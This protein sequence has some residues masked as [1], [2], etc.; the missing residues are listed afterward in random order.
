MYAELQPLWGGAVPRLLYT[1][2]LAG[3]V[4]CIATAQVEGETLSWWRAHA[5]VRDVVMSAWRALRH[6]HPRFVHGDIRADNIVVVRGECGA[7]LKAVFI[8]FA[9]SHLDGSKQ[10][11]AEEDAML[12]QLLEV[13]V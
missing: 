8:D 11:L 13:R 7:P 6:A 2:S 10:Q 9:R 1:G 5:S 12:Q 3:P 4:H